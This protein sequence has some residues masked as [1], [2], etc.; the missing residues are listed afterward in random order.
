MK[1]GCWAQSRAAQAW[2]PD[3]NITLMGRQPPKR[4]NILKSLHK[5]A[6]NPECGEAAK[7]QAK[8]R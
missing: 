1:A 4:H 7:H 8:P 5:I 6:A 3:A 2:Q